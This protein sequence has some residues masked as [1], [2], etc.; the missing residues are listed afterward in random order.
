MYSAKAIPHESSI[1]AYSG[2]LDDITFISCNLRWPYHAKVM[3]IFEM[4]SNTIVIM[5]FFI[6][7]IAKFAAKV[8]NLQQTNNYN[9]GK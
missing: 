4:T 7:V 3:K 1:T 2:V 8:V 6:I 9:Y 5:A